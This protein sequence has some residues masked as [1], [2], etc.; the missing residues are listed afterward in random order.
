MYTLL[1]FSVFVKSIYVYYL[2]CPLIVSTATVCREILF[3]KPVE[4][5]D[6]KSAAVDASKD[7]F[8][9]SKTRRLNPGT[10]FFCFFSFLVVGVS[11]Q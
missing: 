4:E 2:C 1:S 6:K 3:K 10:V 8:F 11:L 9:N 7:A 5:D